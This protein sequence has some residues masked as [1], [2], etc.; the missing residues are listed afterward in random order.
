MYEISKKKNRMDALGS[1]KSD[2]DYYSILGVSKAASNSDI[3][4]A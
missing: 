4:N 1:E 3:K 2:L